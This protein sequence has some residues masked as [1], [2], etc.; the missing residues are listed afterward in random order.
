M[1]MGIVIW[2]ANM[3]LLGGVTRR[4]VLALRLI[5][6]LSELL[7]PMKKKRPAPRASTESAPMTMPAMVPLE[8]FLEG[9]GGVDEEEEVEVGGEEGDEEEMGEGDPSAGKGSPGFRE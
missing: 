1:G 3:G 2:L 6:S 8:S 9:G 4:M 7:R 5:S